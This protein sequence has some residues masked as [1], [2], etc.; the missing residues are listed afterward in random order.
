MISLFN[1]YSI[2][3][4]ELRNLLR[5]W[6]FRI[7]S[8]LSI[9]VIILINTGLFGMSQSP[10]SVKALPSFIPY[11]NILLLNIVQAI[12]G[13][14][15]ASDFMKYDRKLD[16]TDVIYMRS[17]TNAEY[18][19]GKTIGV[20]VLFF[21]L[22]AVVLV[23]SF[24]FNVVISELPFQPML[25]LVYPLLI[26]LPTLIFI[27]GL[28]FLL[29]SILRNQALTFVFLLGYI[30]ITFFFVGGKYDALFDYLAY[31]MPLAWSDFIG[32]GDTAG[33]MMQR[34]MYLL[35][36]TGFIFITIL[37][38]KRLPQSKF[39]NIVSVIIAVGSITGAL[40]LGGTYI[41]RNTTGKA[42]RAEIQT[43][44]KKEAKTPKVSVLSDV[45]DLT[46]N[47]SAIEVSAHISFANETSDPID[48]YLF[49]LNPGLSVTGITRGGT[50]VQFTRD[51]HLIE[52]RP[53]SA[54][55]SGGVDSLTISY[56][57][58][59]D[60]NACFADISEDMREEQFKF[61]L[62]NIGKRYAYIC[63]DYV[64]LTQEALW[65][66]VAG[67][68]YGSAYPVL[69]KKDFIDFTLNIKTKPELTAL[70]QGAVKSTGSGAFSFKP[71]IRLPQLSLAIG[72]YEKKSITVEG[73]EYSV[74]ILKGHDFF[75]Q[76]FTNIGATLPNLITELK[77]DYENKLKL[78][79]P[80]T[81]FSLIET[82]AQF[83]TYPRFWTL[84]QETVQP[85]QALIPE[86]A[87]V[88]F[89]ADF[90]Q[91]MFWMQRSV[92]R[93]NRAMTDEE[94]QGMLLRSFVNDTFVSQPFTFS[95]LRRG[96]SM[97]GGG[98][99]GVSSLL[100]R[101]IMGG[102]PRHYGTYLA[103]PQYYSFSR[104]LFSNDR[105]ILSTA[106]E[107]YLNE[108]VTSSGF[109]G[110]RNMQGMTNEERANLRLTKENL[111]DIMANPGSIDDAFDIIKL[112][113]RYLFARIMGK[114][115]PVK[116]NDYLDSVINSLK[117][118]SVDI[119]S[120][121]ADITSRF[122]VNIKEI[123][124]AIFTQTKLPAFIISEPD[125]VEV[126]EG[127][128]TRY[129]VNFTVT[130][131][132]PSEGLISV[133]FRYSGGGF[134]GGGGRGGGFG[135][136]GM[137]GFRGGTQ[138]AALLKY[139]T[140]PGESTKEI[141]VVLDDRPNTLSIDTLVSLNIP[142]TLSKRLPTPETDI[143]VKPFEGERIIDTPPRSARGEVIVDNEDPGYQSISGN[144]ASFIKRLLVKTEDDA[145]E[146]IGIRFW[147]MPLKWRKTT[148][149]S[150]YGLYRLSAEYIGPGKG[151]NKAVWT[152][153]IPVSGKYNVY[154]YVSRL[155]MPNFR[156]GGGPGGGGPG[157]G[158][159]GGERSGENENIKDFH[160]TVYH[161]DG[162]D[163]I[164]MDMGGAEEGWAQLGTFYFSEGQAKVELTDE[165]NGRIVYADAIRWAPVE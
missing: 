9:A 132:E 133:D 140:I 86:K 54:L 50:A 78:N 42:V 164:D 123:L 155:R 74:A 8:L 160:F 98:R 33:I 115:D 144:S 76:Y 5:S 149:D 58:A 27:F 18:V 116:F 106:L 43:I 105:P 84:N 104:Q 107:M 111:L 96:M 110:F 77:S 69:G 161:D 16:T 130:N 163:P 152:A 151:L 20:L 81:R 62:Y 165:T 28:S 94:M 35:F 65:Y 139:Y 158:G 143:K 100:P 135:G 134:G 150:F 99:G 124:D 88:L 138:S 71:E 19:L 46:H 31:N 85:E 127:G 6:F 93:G 29:M 162:A 120:L 61:L 47:G 7:F 101:F 64:L 34:G 137:M 125:V 39:V 129:Q 75:S 55:A 97:R 24:V 40:A 60:E 14:F 119:D 114:T 90:R 122:G 22:N 128:E 67:I 92:Q 126:I 146:Y 56:A 49:S 142:S 48:R 32:F 15:M 51:H 70:S 83:Y 91:R 102:I 156:R 41:G 95:T 112:E 25:Y 66:P 103:F 136:G 73:V 30:A 37:L 87:F 147:N 1:M 154:F 82:P 109:G 17:M 10:S 52:I 21:G 68:P 118:E 53:S 59:I 45:I 26:S 4:F 117:F 148:N 44:N 80:F 2:A 63:P 3:L 113:S 89:N 153:D 11:L 108:R 72:N 121:D 57:G 145:D 141:G 79:Y 23:N 157:G 13:G 12:I 131:P 36:G 159:P 38:L